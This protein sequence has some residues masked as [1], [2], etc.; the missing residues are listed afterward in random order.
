[1]KQKLIALLTTMAIMVGMFA[2]PVSAA[3]KKDLS[4]DI[5]DTAAYLQTMYEGETEQP[6]ETSY[7]D[8]LYLARA[9][10]ERDNILFELYR[11]NI[12]TE[13]HETGKLEY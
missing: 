10:V 4:Q 13:L 12:A 9:G 6:N 3:E 11:S 7:W 1:M 5:Q 2:F 8:M